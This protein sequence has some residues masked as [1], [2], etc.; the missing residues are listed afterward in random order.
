MF[1][2]ANGIGCCQTDHELHFE[3]YIILLECKL[4]QSPLAVPQMTKLYIPVMKEIYD[5]PIIPVQVCKN[6]KTN[7]PN[8]LADIEVLIEHPRMAIWTWHYLADR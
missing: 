4:T 5:K 8:L 6:L 3:D 2:D 1:E 7:P